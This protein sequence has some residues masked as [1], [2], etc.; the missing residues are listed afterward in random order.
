MGLSHCSK[1]KRVE[2]ITHFLTIPRV[3][4][5]EKDIK[6]SRVK[7]IIIDVI[8]YYKITNRIDDL[9]KEYVNILNFE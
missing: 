9:R 4:H 6:L 3:Q 2:E 8:K 7:G 1:E 5:S